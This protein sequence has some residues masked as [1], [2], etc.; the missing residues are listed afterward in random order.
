MCSVVFMKKT[1]VQP[2][3]KPLQNCAYTSWAMIVTDHVI[4]ISA[5]DRGPHNSPI[6]LFTWAYSTN[7]CKII[8][9]AFCDYIWETRRKLKI[10]I[11]KS[12]QCAW[13]KNVNTIMMITID[14]PEKNIKLCNHESLFCCSMSQITHVGFQPITVCVRYLM[15]VLI[16]WGPD[17]IYRPCFR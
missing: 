15:F 12:V 5:S 8:Q 7:L 2:H 9:A 16:D 17:T 14:N 4:K 13:A 10:M 3:H 6:S 11:T 1:P